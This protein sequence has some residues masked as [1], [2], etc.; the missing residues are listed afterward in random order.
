MT[1]QLHLLL[2]PH[3]LAY[4]VKR[5]S[6]RLRPDRAPRRA[7]A[8]LRADERVR[9]GFPDRR[10]DRR[11]AV[12]AASDRRAG[13]A[14]A[15]C[16]C[17]QRPSAAAAPACR[18]S[19]AA[20]ARRAARRAGPGELS[21]TSSSRPATWS[22]PSDWIYR[23]PDR[24][25]RG[26]AAPSASRRAASSSPTGGEASALPRTEPTAVRR[27]LELTAEQRAG[28]RGAFAHRLSLITGGPGTGKTAS[29]RTIAALAAATGRAGAAGR[30]DRPGG[31]PD[32]RGE[33]RCA[34]DGALGA[35]L[36]PGRGPDPRRG[37]SA[38]LRP[39][40]R[41][42][43]LDGEPRA[44]GDAAAGGRRARTHVVL[45]GDADQLAPVGRGQAVR[46]AGRVRA[47][48]RRRA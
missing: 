48:C 14:P 26:G 42:R 32:D 1:R 8:P 23:P 29:I 18:S 20:G 16:T 13:R 44:D 7:R 37:G 21:S 5:I 11:R 31:D 25:A 34:R 4:L 39:A 41:R 19:A 6:D 43:V 10:P 27:R 45:V 38:A 46:R 28:V 47:S 22:A 36:D 12:G 24:G 15:S 40:D 35:R 3:G 30:A 9:R 17:S 2:A 33:R